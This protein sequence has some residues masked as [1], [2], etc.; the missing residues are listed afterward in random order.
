MT[1]F[2]AVLAALA[3]STVSVAAAHADTFTFSFGDNTDTFYGSGVLTAT[4]NGTGQYLITGVTGTT[5]TGGK[6]SL[7]ISGIEDPGTFE[8][9]DNELALNTDGV[10]KFMGAGLSYMLSNGAQVNI[11][12][13]QFGDS[14]ILER[15][16]GNLVSQRVDYT[17]AATPEPGSFVLLGTGLLGAVGVARRRLFA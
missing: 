15:A 1:H 3:L 2:R 11:Y 7:N 4:M 8:S 13:D 6:R 16:N 5:N 17:V 9:N 10:F 12:T 14:E